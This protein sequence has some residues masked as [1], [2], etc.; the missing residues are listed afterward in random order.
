M[1]VLTSGRHPHEVVLNI[2]Y[3][4]GGTAGVLGGETV[5][6]KTV[7]GSLP[8]WS[9]FTFF[10]ALVV[11]AVISLIGI[12]TLKGVLGPAVER[13]GL[14]VTTLDLVGYGVA[15]FGIIGISAFFF[16]VLTIA[17]GV[18]NIWRALQIGT[19]LKAVR[20]GAQATGTVA[21]LGGAL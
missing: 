7:L 5:S 18:A 1:I 21:Q 11:G 20:A 3:L 17:L 15:L 4:I 9:L 16:G 8:S 19:E 13:I 2:V 10:L 12:F 6:G 14:V